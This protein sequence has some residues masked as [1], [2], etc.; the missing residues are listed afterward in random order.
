MSARYRA[1]A[2]VCRKPAVASTVHLARD[3]RAERTFGGWGL[4]LAA[5]RAPLDFVCVCVCVCVV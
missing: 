4:E 5:R 2:G 1:C 3:A